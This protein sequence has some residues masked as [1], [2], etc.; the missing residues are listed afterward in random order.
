MVSEQP[1][2][3]KQN[4]EYLSEAEKAAAIRALSREEL[5][6]LG[7]YARARWFFRLSRA[8]Q[9]DD[10]VNDAIV[11]VVK[12][13]KGC[14]KGFPITAALRTAMRS[15]SSNEHVREAKLA[16]DG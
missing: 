4:V 3:K 2:A 16:G 5:L 8:K 1:A 10:L 15:V 9:P 12:G 13:Q 7:N 6:S 11:R 14:P